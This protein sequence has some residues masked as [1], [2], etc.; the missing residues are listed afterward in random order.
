MRHL[1]PLPAIL[2]FEAAA[3]HEN[4]TAAANELGLTQAAVS[5]QMRVL[6]ERLGTALF[7]REKKR[8]KL[9]EAAAGRRGR[10]A[11]HLT[12]WT[13]PLRSFAPKATRC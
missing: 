6:E 2:V 7:R 12:S 11:A 10:L 4:F 9:T 5:Y 8:V 1:P 3:R 13:A